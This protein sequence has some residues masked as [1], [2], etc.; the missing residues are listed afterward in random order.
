MYNVAGNVQQLFT[1]ENVKWQLRSNM[2]LR[3]P[4]KN[5]VIQMFVACSAQTTVAWSK[6]SNGKKAKVLAV[7]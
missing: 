7:S 5:V 2:S 6:G 1:K 4:E 3:K